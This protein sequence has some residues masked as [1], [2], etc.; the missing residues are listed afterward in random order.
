M[1]VWCWWSALLSPWC[2]IL[3]VIKPLICN[4]E[5]YFLS[6]FY[7]TSSYMGFVVCKIHARTHR[8]IEKLM[9]ER[10]CFQNSQLNSPWILELWIAWACLQSRIDGSIVSSF[11]PPPFPDCCTCSLLHL[12]LLQCIYIFPHSVSKIHIDI[13]LGEKSHCQA[14]SMHHWIWQRQSLLSLSKRMICRPIHWSV[15]F[16]DRTLHLWMIGIVLCEHSHIF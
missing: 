2:S 13:T 6:L 8:E 1:K 4:S 3:S 16:V 7:V 10:K 11:I 12:K 14:P 5:D 9:C 15:S